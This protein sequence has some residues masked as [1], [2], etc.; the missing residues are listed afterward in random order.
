[1]Y[2]PKTPSPPPL[3]AQISTCGDISAS[4]VAEEPETP[5]VT[6]LATHI[7]ESS[8]QPAECHHVEPHSELNSET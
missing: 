5:V 7:T 1:M 6:P 4:H 2:I 3:N 8:A